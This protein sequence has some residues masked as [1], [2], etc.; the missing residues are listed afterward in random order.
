[1]RVRTDLLTVADGLTQFPSRINNIERHSQLE[2]KV[3]GSL[4]S[5]CTWKG[6]KSSFVET[7]EEMITAQEA[8]HSRL[9]VIT[10]VDDPILKFA[11]HKVPTLFSRTA[12]EKINSIKFILYL[13]EPNCCS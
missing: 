10:F 4:C 3:L 12:S 5:R 9:E 6:H 2:R 7:V 1:M 11:P 13:F 8:T